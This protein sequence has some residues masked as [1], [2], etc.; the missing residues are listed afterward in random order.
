[1]TEKPLIGTWDAPE[2]PR[3]K[4]MQTDKIIEWGN[5]RNITGPECAPYQ[6]GKI[7]E[8]V[9]ETAGAFL[10]KDRDA[11]RDGIGDSFVTLILFSV[12]NGF[13]PEECLE[14]AWQ[15]IKDRTGK[16]VDGVFIKD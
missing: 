10:K 15:E 16:K 12:Q 7:M 4:T 8:E 14:A 9:G 13:T 11:L 2:P 1:M 3:T 6:L 5:A